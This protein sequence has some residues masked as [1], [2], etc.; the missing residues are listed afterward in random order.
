MKRIEASFIFSSHVLV[1]SAKGASARGA[2]SRDQ[3]RSLKMGKVCNLGKQQVLSKVSFNCF[4][5]LVED[6]EFSEN[7]EK[8]EWV[9]YIRWK[10]NGGRTS[11][12]P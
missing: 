3:I 10:T 8:E 9:Q 1:M 12:G 7:L 5:F 2:S 6:G 4:R 11:A